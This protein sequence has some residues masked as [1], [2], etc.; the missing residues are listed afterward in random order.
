ML[1]WRE[2][3]HWQA[4][5]FGQLQRAV[6]GGCC[7]EAASGSTVFR[8]RGKLSLA[9]P[10]YKDANEQCQEDSDPRS[11]E[12]LQLESLGWALGLSILPWPQKSTVQR[13]CSRHTGGVV[14]LIRAVEDGLCRLFAS[15]L[16]LCCYGG[17]RRSKVSV[18]CHVLLNVKEAACVSGEKWCVVCLVCG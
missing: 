7:G 8:F 4:N 13:K 5:S 14:R 2:S 10:A 9:F 18:F 6:P 12:N 1:Y 3:S 16:E 15:L 11:H 17:Q